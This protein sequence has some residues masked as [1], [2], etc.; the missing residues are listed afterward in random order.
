[1]SNDI[2]WSGIAIL[3]GFVL[4]LIGVILLVFDRYSDPMPKANLAIM[5][6]GF[7]FVFVGSIVKL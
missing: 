6:I 2:D 4:I 7:V 3:F 1:M 5:G